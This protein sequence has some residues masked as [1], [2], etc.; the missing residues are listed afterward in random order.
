MEKIPYLKSLGITA[1]ELMPVQEFND[2]SISHKDPHTGH[3][4]KNY[5]RLRSGGVLC[6]E[7][8]LQ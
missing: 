2:T 4:F 3:L 6:A 7:G 1:V 5:W 8:F